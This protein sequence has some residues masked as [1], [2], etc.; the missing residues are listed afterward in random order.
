MGSLSTMFACVCAFPAQMVWKRLQV[1]GIGGRPVKYAGMVQCI[2]MVLREEGVKGV[3]AGL[4]ANLVKLA[5]SGAV[6]FWALEQFKSAM[7]W[8]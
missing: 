3:Y 1:Q 8:K 6:Q 4:P 7:G 5:P 2:S